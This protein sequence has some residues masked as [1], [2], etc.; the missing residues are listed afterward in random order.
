[1]PVVV[2]T[3]KTKP[4]QLDA[5]V[6]VFRA[7]SP[8]VHKENGCLLYAVHTG[9]DRLVVVENWSDAATLDAHSRGAALTAIAAGVSD[10]LAEP[11]DVAV[12]DAVPMGDPEKSTL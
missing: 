11:M 8:A 3:L 12:L 9:P 5:A 10:L 4:G 2:A 1:M 6:E 7:H